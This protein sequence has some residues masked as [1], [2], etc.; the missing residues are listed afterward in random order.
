M[1][2]VGMVSLKR[3]PEDIRQ[4]EINEKDERFIKI[5]EK[6]AYATFY[7]TMIGLSVVELVFAW[8]EY[9]IPC[10]IIIGLMAVHIISYFVFLYRYNRK[11]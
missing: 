9:L 8:L 3:K 2:C 1:G 6:S 10:F 4:Q 7:V 11:F 5:R